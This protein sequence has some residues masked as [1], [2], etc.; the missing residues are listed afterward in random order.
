MK[1]YFNVSFAYA[2]AGMVAGVFY[3]EFTKALGFTGSTMLLRVHPHLF[4]LGMFL[5]LAVALFTKEQKLEQQ[6]TFRLFLRFHNIGLPLTAIMM[7]VRGIFQV[8]GTTLSPALDGALSGI[9]GLG[10]ILTGA[11]LIFLLLS[12]RKA[13]EA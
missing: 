5:F 13:Y 2:I 9:A 11:G 3:R 1:K 6:K 10:H 7:V 4:V 8:L 12:L